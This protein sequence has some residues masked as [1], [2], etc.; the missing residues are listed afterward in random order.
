L[1]WFELIPALEPDAEKG[2]RVVTAGRQ[3]RTRASILIDHPDQ[4][5]GTGTVATN[6]S[7]I[8]TATPAG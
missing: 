8:Q 5:K 2:V 6:F 7:V 3:S 4:T 1:A